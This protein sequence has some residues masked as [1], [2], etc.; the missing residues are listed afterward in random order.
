MKCKH[1]NVSE[2]SLRPAS[3]LPASM[4]WC[5]DCG[6]VR[7][8]DGTRVTMPWRAPTGLLV[9]SGCGA[10]SATCNPELWAQSKKCCPDCEHR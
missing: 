9:C 7:R 4:W 8:M 3:E 6:A 10:T 1:V 5:H 2:F